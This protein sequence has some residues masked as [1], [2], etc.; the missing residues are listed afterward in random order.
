MEKYLKLLGLSGKKTEWNSLEPKVRNHIIIKLVGCVLSLILFLVLY[1]VLSLDTKVFL[2]L[3]I[4]LAYEVY[5]LNKDYLFFTYSGYLFI[6]GTILNVEQPVKEKPKAL[7]H[8]VNYG[9]SFMT[10][11]TEGNLII[12]PISHSKSYRTGLSVK[13]Y[14]EK[15]SLSQETEDSYRILSPVLVIVE[16]TN[17]K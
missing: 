13:V 8:P 1:F 17:L 15:N 14:F 9:K 4:I 11:E 12:V 6:E 3:L 5:A 10:V 2:L 7:V 16:K